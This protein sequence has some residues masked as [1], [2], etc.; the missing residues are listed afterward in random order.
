MNLFNY[1]IWSPNPEIFPSIDWIEVRWYGLLFAAGFIISQQLMYH[2][3]KKEGKP[4][5]D[6]DSLTLWMIISTIV[7]ARLGHVIFYE[8]MRYLEDP[9]SILKTWEGGLASHGAA[10][11]ILT[12]IYLYANY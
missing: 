12:A 4:Q 3:F 7:G 9:I 8:P 5:Q 2:I 10:I 1:I 11:G 6:V